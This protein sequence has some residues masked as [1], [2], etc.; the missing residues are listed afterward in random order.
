[1]H[2][3]RAVH[4]DRAMHGDKAMHGSSKRWA[5]VGLMLRVVGR[6]GRAVAQASGPGLR[7][8]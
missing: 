8:C 3:D 6:L 5:R 2:G 4:G 7:V 1:M